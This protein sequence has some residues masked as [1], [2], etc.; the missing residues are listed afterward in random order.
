L[1]GR[2]WFFCLVA[3]STHRTANDDELSRSHPPFTFGLWEPTFRS[4]TS[5]WGAL[6]A[7]CL[8]INLGAQ[9][10]RS[11]AAM[12]MRY[13][14]DDRP[15][16]RPPSL[17]GACPS[18]LPQAFEG[19]LPYPSWHVKQPAC[20]RYVDVRGQTRRSV[21]ATINMVL[22]A[23][24]RMTAPGGNGQS[25][26]GVTAV[27]YGNPASTRWRIGSAAMDCPTCYLGVT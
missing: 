1:T 3:V 4:G 18:H 7:E 21:N 19:L 16:P 25:Q 17:E 13:R 8:A 6:G 5:P 14:R 24:T 10:G 23:V 20:H 27:G 2:I 22:Q 12:G 9:H 11:L 26:N 15:V